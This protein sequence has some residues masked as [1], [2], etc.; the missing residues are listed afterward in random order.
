LV[1][2]ELRDGR[3]TTHR[4]RET[5]MTTEERLGKLERE[6]AALRSE[7]RTRKVMIEDEDGA[8]RAALS[9]SNDWPG[10]GLYDEKGTLRAV[11]R[12]DEDGPTLSL[13]DAKGTPRI[14][15]RMEEDGPTLALHDKDGSLRALLG[16]LKYGPGLVLADEKG[17]PTWSAP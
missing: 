1:R 6:V 16:V 14:W 9:V 7:V 8:V 3:I 13:G 12:L 4:R 5:P 11:L 2:A 17:N 15:L 10:L